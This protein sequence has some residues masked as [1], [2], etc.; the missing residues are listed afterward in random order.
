VIASERFSDTKI[1]VE[2]RWSLLDVLEANIVLDLFDE[3]GRK[4]T[5]QR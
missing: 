2:E 4:A 3:A 1:D 5:Q